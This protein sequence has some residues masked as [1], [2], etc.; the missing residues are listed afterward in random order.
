MNELLS[1]F[2]TAVS[3][4]SSA[5]WEALDDSQSGWDQRGRVL[6]EFGLAKTACRQQGCK[7]LAR[8]LLDELNWY[9]VNSL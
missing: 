1:F 5:L 6:Q 7:E 4:L 8:F 2:H 9:L 3:F